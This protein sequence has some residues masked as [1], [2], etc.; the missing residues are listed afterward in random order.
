[1][2]IMNLYYNIYIYIYIISIANVLLT[3]FT[4][5]GPGR[6]KMAA[7]PGRARPGGALGLAHAASL[8]CQESKICKMG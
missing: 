7:D 6:A 3:C 2:N 4:L 5:V 8:A 1:M